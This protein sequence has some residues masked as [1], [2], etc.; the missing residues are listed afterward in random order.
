MKETLSPNERL[1]QAAQ[2]GSLKG[3]KEVIEAGADVNYLGEYRE[4]ALFIACQY[5][6]PR[7]AR[8][9][10][11]CPGIDITMGRWFPWRQGVAGLA[12]PSEELQLNTPLWAAVNN[13]DLV[14]TRMLLKHAD[15]EKYLQADEYWASTVKTTF[16]YD[17]SP[18][19]LDAL[20]TASEPYP[21][22]HQFTIDKAVDLAFCYHWAAPDLEE[23]FT[24]RGKGE[25]ALG[26]TALIKGIQSLTCWNAKGQV[27]YALEHAEKIC[28]KA[29]LLPDLLATLRMAKKFK[30]S[31]CEKILQ[32]T[33]ESIQ[34]RD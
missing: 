24:R 5:Q 20:L 12:A 11:D 9:L 16:N 3:V 2:K 31:E 21:Q 25:L 14:I 7:I 19:M 32:E 1:I 10:L 23:L 18:Y 26:R 6:H 22:L 13:D 4:S 17:F 15:K 34:R 8:Y 27:S 28:D 33:I 29:Q 30:S